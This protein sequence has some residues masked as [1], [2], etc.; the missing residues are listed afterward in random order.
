MSVVHLVSRLG[1]KLAALTPAVNGMRRASAEAVF[2]GLIGQGALVISGVLLARQLGPEQ[3]GYLALLMLWPIVISKIGELGLPI[4]TA[5]YIAREPRSFRHVVRLVGILARRQVPMLVIVHAVV[6]TAFLI[7]KPSNLVGAAVLTIMSVP[8]TM[9]GDYGLSMLQGQQ[10]FRTLN[11]LRMVNPAFLCPGLLVLT[12]MNRASLLSM[13]AVAVL[14]I[15]VSG[16][17]YLVAALRFHPTG[18][19]GTSAISGHEL[20][21]FGVRGLLGSTY[22]VETFRIDQLAV[23]LFL[24]PIALGLY[25]VGVAFTN[26]PVFV[27]QSLAYIAYPGVAAETDRSQRRRIIWQFFWLFIALSVATVIVL[28]AT[29]AVLVP[30]FFGSQFT[31]SIGIARIALVG[32]LVLSARRILAETLRGAGYPIAGTMA[33]ATLLAL[34]LPAFLVGGHFWGAQGVA[35]AVALAGLASLVVLLAFEARV[36]GRTEKRSVRRDAW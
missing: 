21:R 3:R 13:T 26:I 32:A 20:I 19:A 2:V 34:L 11:L 15:F 8:S 18:P 24:S 12:A 30:W 9:A 4:A 10:R 14:A 6:L 1:D 23:G 36:M 16:V 22:P 33:E 17:A 5:Y 25:V 29:I 31:A 28:E 7:G 35:G 27:S